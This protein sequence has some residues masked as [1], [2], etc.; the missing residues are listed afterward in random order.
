[1]FIVEFLF[2]YCAGEHFLA[3]LN[4]QGG[5][6]LCVFR[7]DESHADA[8]IDGEAVVAGGNFADGFACFVQDGIAVTWDGFVG[9]FDADEFL[10]H[11]V[12][13]LLCQGLSSLQNMERP[14][15]TGEM[16]ALSS[17]P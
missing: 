16:S 17:S 5:V 11:A 15:M 6:E 4:L 9:Q 14:A 7:L 2:N 3:N 8:F 10:C 1:M 12:C 13:F